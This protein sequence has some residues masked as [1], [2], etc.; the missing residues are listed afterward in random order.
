MPM[1]FIYS[2]IKESPPV[3]HVLYKCPE[4]QEIKKGDKVKA[5]PLAAERRIPCSVCLQTI[6]EW[7][8]EVG[9]TY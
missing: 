6:S 8:K 7:I 9:S 4:A 1:D 3:Y 5:A 2:T